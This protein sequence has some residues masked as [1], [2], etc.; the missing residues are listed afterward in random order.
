LLKGD[1]LI[2]MYCP[3]IYAKV[4][5][6]ETLV[7]KNKQPELRIPCYED[8]CPIRIWEPEKKVGAATIA[9]RCGIIINICEECPQLHKCKKDAER[10]EECRQE[11][12]DSMFRIPSE[13]QPVDFITPQA[14]APVQRHRRSSI[15]II[16]EPTP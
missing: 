10:K 1:E 13:T 2:I 14:E 15:E 9:A 6:D 5:C 12:I 3:L 7:P 11:R 8:K 4:Q 16:G